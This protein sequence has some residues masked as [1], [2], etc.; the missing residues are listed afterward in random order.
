[1]RRRNP[2]RAYDENGRKTPPLTL[3]EPQRDRHTTE[4]ATCD[5]LFRPKIVIAYPL[6]QVRSSLEWLSR[7]PCAQR[8]AI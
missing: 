6:T 8:V 1:M 3:G 2:R 4:V 7:M 5:E